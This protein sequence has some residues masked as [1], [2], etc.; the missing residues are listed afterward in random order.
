MESKHPSAEE[1]QT[2]ND[3]KLSQDCVEFDFKKETPQGWK[4]LPQL[5]PVK[6]RKFI[7][8]FSTGK[9]HVQLF[10]QMFILVCLYNYVH[11]CKKRGMKLTLTTLTLGMH[12]TF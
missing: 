10:L 8:H 9:F 11:L 5:N 3:L 12:V 2:L 4:V 7:N 6:V 1:G